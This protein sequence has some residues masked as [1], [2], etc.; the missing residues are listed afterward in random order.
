LV[1]L[2]ICSNKYIYALWKS[3]SYVIYL[4]SHLH[5]CGDVLEHRATLPFCEMGSRSTDCENYCLLGC[6]ALLSGR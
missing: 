3:T 6:Y 1:Y 4:H 5:H 2:Q